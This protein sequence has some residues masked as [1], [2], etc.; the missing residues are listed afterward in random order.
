[1]VIYQQKFAPSRYI[2]E[3]VLNRHHHVHAENPHSNVATWKTIGA[4]C[5][6][7]CYDKSNIVS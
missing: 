5:R 3:R 7:L 4:F 2:N 1:M 6:T